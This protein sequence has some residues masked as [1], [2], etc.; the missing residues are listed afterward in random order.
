LILVKHTSKSALDIIEAYGCPDNGEFPGTIFFDGPS[1]IV[2][3]CGHV[4]DAEGWIEANR[5]GELDASEFAE[6]NEPS[7]CSE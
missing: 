4:V 6:E 7:R 1:E 5:D 2:L 3:E